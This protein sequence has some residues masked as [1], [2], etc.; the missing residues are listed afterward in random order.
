MATKEAEAKACWAKIQQKDLEV[1][2][3]LRGCKK[4]GR[5][6]ERY[7]NLLADSK[8]LYDEYF[9]ITGEKPYNPHS[10]ADN[11]SA[12]DRTARAFLGDRKP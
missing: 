10:L 8:K 7:K 2:E 12:S 4:Q 9:K 1:A 3:E 5:R 6:S 11:E